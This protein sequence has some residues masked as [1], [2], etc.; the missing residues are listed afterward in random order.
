ML[1]S[2]SAC[3]ES[4]VEM[5]RNGTL[6]RDETKTLG[7][8]FGNK[9]LFANGKWEAFDADDGSHVVQFTGSLEGLQEE[10][11]EMRQEFEKNPAGFTLAAL[12]QA[13]EMGGV[14]VAMILKSGI[15][16]EECRYEIQFLMSKRKAGA[17]EVGNSVLKAKAKMPGG[18]MAEE[19]FNDEDG[20]VLDSL[21]EGDKAGIAAL[22]VGK[23]MVSGLFKGVLE[24]INR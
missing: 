17:F 23:M 14:G 11:D 6:D 21:Y 5:V 3:T 1:F 9:A 4:R 20:D 15:R 16:I 19:E 7:D 13:G 18:K 2:L 22:V 8:V 12:A 10:M 24:G